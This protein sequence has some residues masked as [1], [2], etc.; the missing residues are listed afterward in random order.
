MKSTAVCTSG[1]GLVLYEA[2]PSRD[3]VGEWMVRGLN[4]AGG[5]AF[6]ARFSGR[7]ARERA[8]EYAKWKNGVIARSTASAG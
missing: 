4:G 1:A 6:T 5:E 3:V 2:S 7:G 8:E